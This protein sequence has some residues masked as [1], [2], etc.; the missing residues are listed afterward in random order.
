MSQAIKVEEADAIAP[1]SNRAE[2]V[3]KPPFRS[4]PHDDDSQMDHPRGPLNEQ[5][6]FFL[7]NLPPSVTALEMR[8]HFESYGNVS[9]VKLIYNKSTG[10][11]M[12][13]GFLYLMDAET[14]RRVEEYSVRNNFRI[15]FAN[16]SRIHLQRNDKTRRRPM[17]E[18]RPPRLPPGVQ[19]NV[20]E[21]PPLRP[22]TSP[23]LR[24]GHPAGPFPPHPRH[25][26]PRHPR[27]QPD[28][29]APYGYQSDPRS[30]DSGYYDELDPPTAE[31]YP[32]Q[33]AVAGHYGP[34]GGYEDYPQS[35]DEVGGYN[36]YT[37]GHP[38][39]EYSH[40]HSHHGYGDQE[41][42]YPNSNEQVEYYD[43]GQYSEAENYQQGEYYEGRHSSEAYSHPQRQHGVAGQEVH[44]EY[45][46]NQQPAEASYH[47]R[48]DYADPNYAY[49][50]DDR[51]SA[52]D[53]LDSRAPD[54]HGSYRPNSGN[55]RGGARGG[56]S[57]GGRGGGTRGGFSH[58]GAARGGF[59]HG[60]GAR[61]GFSHGG[62]AR[63]EFSHGGRGRGGSGANHQRFQ[64]RDRPY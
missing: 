8:R 27:F 35:H 57:H 20:E 29:H 37:H 5:F 53:H 25:G 3:E 24:H 54:G 19:S 11:S 34:T 52:S 50:H 9:F 64:R 46:H 58:G 7:A 6:K 32:D 61:G 22:G 45:S 13:Y 21:L 17:R 51:H 2:S 43:G 33:H 14:D 41:Q 55:F 38:E 10:V 15:R 44:Y 26:P 56:F 28:S 59:S 36:Q 49:P 12:G 47:S 18:S 48:Q 4:G 16:F 1:S 23:R 60:S 42:G 63:G 30:Y 39:Q 40:Q 31:Y 62:G